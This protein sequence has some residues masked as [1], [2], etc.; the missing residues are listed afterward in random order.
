MNSHQQN[1]DLFLKSGGDPTLASR[2]KAPTLENRARIKHLLSNFPKTFQEVS[3]SPKATENSPKKIILEKPRQR[4]DT[5]QTS[6][7][8]KFLG[9]ISQYPA[10][11][12]PCYTEAYSLWLELCSLKL[13]LNVISP[14]D[15]KAA[16]QLQTTMIRKI[17][18]YDKCKNALDYYNKHKAIIPIDSKRNFYGLS[19]LELDRE[20][21]NLASNICKRKQTIAKK[22]SELPDPD[23]SL[24]QRRVEAL[25]RKIEELEELILDEEKILELI[26]RK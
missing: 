19:D 17:K 15:E 10:D 25:Q 23:S 24:Y 1:I 9:L 11:L 6:E 18:R 2:Y 12:H 16:Y 14:E 3:N 8:P 13:Q 22:E 26:D 4:M 20:R 5:G 21:R 7:K